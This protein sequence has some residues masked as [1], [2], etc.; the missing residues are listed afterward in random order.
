M[1]TIAMKNVRA[2]AFIPALLIFCGQV[3]A[4]QA[5]NEH[6]NQSSPTSRFTNNANGTVTDVRTGLMWQR[7]AMG[8]TFSDGGTP[9]D[10]ADDTCTPE[11]VNTFKWDQ[12]LQGAAERNTQGGFAGF[13]DWRLPNLK[14]LISIVEPKCADPA[15]NESIFPDTP[16]SRFLSASP[17]DAATSNV[18]SV[19]IVDFAS[20][21]DFGALA[22]T[23][24]SVSSVRL[25]RSAN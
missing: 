22:T 15:I 4:Q 11:A 2:L 14:E 3:G 10:L 19:L 8:Y 9:T 18:T 1:E 24:S 6:I 17:A 5:C 25:V 20:G 7:C 13:T 23:V 16:P 12:A 21:F